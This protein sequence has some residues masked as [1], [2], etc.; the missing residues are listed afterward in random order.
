MIVIIPMTLYAVVRRYLLLAMKCHYLL[1]VT[2]LALISY[3][4]WMRR[5]KSL[6]CL[7]VAAAL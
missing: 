6:W 4:V 3:H 2:R 1:V 5:S 7:V